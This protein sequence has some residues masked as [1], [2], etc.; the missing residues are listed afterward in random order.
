[1]AVKLVRAGL[2]FKLSFSRKLATSRIS[3]AK[4]VIEY[5]HSGGGL[6]HPASQVLDQ[7]DFGNMKVHDIA[8]T[9]DSSRLVGVGPLLRSPTGLQ[10]SRSRVEKR[11][12]GMLVEFTLAV[13][14]EVFINFPVYNAESRHIER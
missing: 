3:K 12:V 9:P 5:M 1:M 11:L 6:C 13:K 10:P 8:I 7:Y 2:M 14:L 4:W